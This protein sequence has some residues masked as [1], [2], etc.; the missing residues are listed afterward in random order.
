MEQFE[1]EL[2]VEEGFLKGKSPGVYLIPLQ[3]AQIEILSQLNSGFS[4]FCEF[5]KCPEGKEE[6]VY[7]Q[8]LVAN[9]LGQE[10]NGST[11][12][13]NER[14]NVLTI[15]QIVDYNMEYK[16]FKEFLEDFVNMV[17]FWQDKIKAEG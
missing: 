2:G 11:I 16:D 14:G 15:S 10:T 9:L 12:G 3:N 6:T 7:F 1:K 17:G 4:I 5:A 13:L 8:S